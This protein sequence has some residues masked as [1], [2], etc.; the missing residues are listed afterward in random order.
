MKKETAGYQVLA[1]K[2][3]EMYGGTSKEANIMIRNVAE[4]L[5]A[6]LKEDKIIRF[7]QKFTLEQVTRA[8]RSSTLPDGRKIQSD[9]FQ[10]IKLKISP[11]LRAEL[12]A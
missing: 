4:V 2:Y 3:K 12:N 10:T 5:V 11:E 6:C 9:D 7:T 1:D 8:G